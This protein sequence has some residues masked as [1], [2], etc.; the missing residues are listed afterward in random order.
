LTPAATAVEQQQQDV[1]TLTPAITIQLL[2]A[3]MLLVNSLRAPAVQIQMQR[4]MI[5]QHSLMMVHALYWDVFMT[6][7]AIMILPQL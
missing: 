6:K 7:R 2:L 5:L 4:T 1:W 3:M